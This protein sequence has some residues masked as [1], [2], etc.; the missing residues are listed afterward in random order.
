MNKIV[1]IDMDNVLV[2]FK[3]ALNQLDDKTLEIYNNR[4]DEIPNIFRLMNPMK[5]AVKSIHLLSKKYNVFILTT[6][7]WL[8]NTALQDKLNWIKKYFGESPSS[9]F[10]KKVIFSHRKDL[11]KGDYLID[12]RTKNGA[13]QFEGTLLQFGTNKFP[14][15]KS[16]LEYLL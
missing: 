15:W 10:H 13:G 11:L 7:P 2:D 8:N 6:S 12:D 9:I 5:D 4:L 16:I 3:S 14:H 1:Y